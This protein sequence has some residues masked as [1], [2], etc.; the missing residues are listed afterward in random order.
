MKK[1]V[2]IP[3]FVIIVVIIGFSFIPMLEMYQLYKFDKAND[4]RLGE[5]QKYVD[6]SYKRCLLSEVRADGTC[7]LS[8]RGYNPNTGVYDMGVSGVAQLNA[9]RDNLADPYDP[10]SIRLSDEAFARM[11]NP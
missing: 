2:I 7:P 9:E 1:I 3:I 8:S 4:K 11:M 6:S 10:S 5:G